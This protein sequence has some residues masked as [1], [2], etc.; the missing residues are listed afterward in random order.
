VYGSQT[1]FLRS[2]FTLFK[3]ATLLR[4]FVLIPYVSGTVKLSLDREGMVCTCDSSGLLL[5]KVFFL[6]FS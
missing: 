2:M 6:A 3:R 5:S 4:L 1:Q